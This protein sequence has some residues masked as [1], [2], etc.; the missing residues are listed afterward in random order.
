MKH[1][2]TVNDVVCLKAS[3]NMEKCIGCKQLE[4]QSEMEYITYIAGTYIHTCVDFIC[5]HGQNTKGDRLTEIPTELEL[6]R[7]VLAANNKAD[8]VFFFFFTV[9]VIL[10]CFLI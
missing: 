9:T 2:S 1:P 8:L 4:I 10:G 5:T 6:L 3:D 7:V